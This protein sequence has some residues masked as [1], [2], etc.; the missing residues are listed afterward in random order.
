MRKTRPLMLDNTCQVLYQP[1]AAVIQAATPF[2][3]RC[4]RFPAPMHSSGLLLCQEEEGGWK[5]EIW[6]QL[7][8]FSLN[9]R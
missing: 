2:I 8:L 1:R 3:L 4:R 6:Y 9:H 5:E 7:Y